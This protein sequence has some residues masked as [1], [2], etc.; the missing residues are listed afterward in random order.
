MDY[1][2]YGA[3]YLDQDLRRLNE[4]ALDLLWRINPE[5]LAPAPEW[6][7]ALLTTSAQRATWEL[8]HKL[9]LILDQL[10]DVETSGMAKN[11]A[12]LKGKLPK[13]GYPMRYCA[14]DLLDL[15]HGLTELAYRLHRREART[16]GPELPGRRLRWLAEAVIAQAEPVVDAVSNSADARKGGPDVPL[17]LNRA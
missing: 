8:M 15:N 11:W 3:S 9:L 16:I 17:V 12:T 2:S 10:Y 7:P 6:L 13:T 14:D 5:A 4:A 1:P